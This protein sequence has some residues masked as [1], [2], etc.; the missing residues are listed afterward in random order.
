MEKIASEF[1]ATCDER[2]LTGIAVLIAD[3]GSPTI[4]THNLTAA[5]APA[6][7]AALAGGV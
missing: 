2:N 1:I 7:L 4:L 3:D 6:V 5:N